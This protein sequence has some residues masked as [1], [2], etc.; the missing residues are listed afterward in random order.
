MIATKSIAEQLCLNCGLC[1]NGVLFKDVELQAGDSSAHLASLGFPIRIRARGAAN[2]KSPKAKF[3]QPCAALCADN[4]CRAYPDRP[5]RC[6]EFECAVFKAVQTGDVELPAAL[7]TIRSA[8]QRAER[9]R[10]LLRETGD[11]NEGLALSLRFKQ[12]RRRMESGLAGEAEIDTFAELTL[13]VHAL[14]VLLSQE[15]YPEPR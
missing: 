3:S 15:F 8:R 7:R 6:R 4:C 1:C 12:T 11:T 10:S 5:T 14:N 2:G 9:V 13:A